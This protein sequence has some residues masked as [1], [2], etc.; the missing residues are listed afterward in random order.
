MSQAPRRKVVV[1]SMAYRGDVFPYV[2]IAS[3]LARAGYDVVYVVPREFHPLFAGEPFRCADSGTDFS[4]TMLDEHAAFVNRWGTK[5]GGVMLLQLFLGKLT[6]PHLEVL[7]R[8]LD[9]EMADADLLITHPVAA[10]VGAMCAEKRHV[11][12]I[13]GDL[14]PMSVPSEYT[15]LAGMPY[16]GRGINRAL[17]RFT[18]SKLS[19]PISCAKGFRD[20]R[21]KLGVSSE[22]W[23]MIDG[24]LSPQS[25]LGLAPSAYVPPQ[26]DWPGNYRLVGFTSWAGPDGGA[27][28]DAVEEFL[29]NRD[30]P[31]IVT[32]G[33]S[34]ASARPHVFEAAMSALDERRTPGIFLVSNETLAARLTPQAG[35]RH[36]VRPFVPLAPLLS[37]SQAIVHSGAHGTNSLALLAGVPSV[38]VPCLFDQVAHAR[39]QE[40]LGTGIWVHR[41]VQLPAALS[42]V[43]NDQGSHH[44]AAQSFAAKIADED[45]AAAVVAE[46]HSLLGA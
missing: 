16:L 38:I 10:V 44:D 37:R 24:R 12:M 39:R 22:G 15:P 46:V 5:L 9:A 3:A 36:L 19:D 8:A 11:P 7:Y 30:P 18:R 43:L 33:T 21:T 45:G 41:Q 26:P 14:F 1:Y 6:L 35:H 20:F 27:L 25:N 13:V 28:D 29:D 17:I 4:P 23:N 2:P 32:L 34:A 40:E 31:I 42:R